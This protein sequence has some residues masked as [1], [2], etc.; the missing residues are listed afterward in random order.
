[1][2]LHAAWLRRVKTTSELWF[3]SDSRLTGGRTWDACPKLLPFDRGDAVLGFAGDTNDAYPLMVQ[4][5]YSLK[6][7]DKIMSRG[8]DLTS[9]VG[10]VV[11]ILDSMWAATTGLPSGAAVHPDCRFLFGGYCWRFNAF[12][13]WSIVPNTGRP[14]FHATLSL[15]SSKSSLKPYV[16]L[17][18]TE[19]IAEAYKTMSSVSGASAQVDKQPLLVLRDIIRKS[20]HRGIGGPLQVV[21]SYRHLNTRPYA[22][23]W[24]SRASGTLT[25]MGRTLQAHER[26]RF[27]ALDPDTL[28]TE[29]LWDYRSVGSSLGGGGVKAES[30]PTTGTLE[31]EGKSP[32]SN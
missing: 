26:T 10:T 25:L 16:F 30:D 12:K 11:G 1:M 9:L 32:G 24:P 22:V 19:A 21:K 18:D 14:S 28:E 31:S 17:G 3:A 2:T 29:K 13:I 5:A 20:T 7:H 4:L 23:F 27:L 15:D 8:Q 6:Y